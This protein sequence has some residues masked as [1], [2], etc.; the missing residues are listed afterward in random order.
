MA[1]SKKGNIYVELDESLQ[2]NTLK[3]ARIEVSISVTLGKKMERDST[4]AVEKFIAQE[5]DMIAKDFKK[6]MKKQTKKLIEVD[7][8]K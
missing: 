4:R 5:M 1:I 6:F 8:E 3:D 2:T 7:M